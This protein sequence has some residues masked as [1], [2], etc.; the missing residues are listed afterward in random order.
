M[1]PKTPGAEV[2]YRAG[3]EMRKNLWW[4][5]FSCGGGTTRSGE[6]PVHLLGTQTECPGCEQTVTIISVSPT[7]EEMDRKFEEYLSRTQPA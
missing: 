6:K 4:V 7:R 5:G 3:E 1:K 2:L